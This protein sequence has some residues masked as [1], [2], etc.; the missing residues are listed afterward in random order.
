MEAGAL[1]TIIL[2][3]EQVDGL[4]RLFWE[5]ETPDECRIYRFHRQQ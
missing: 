2:I 4:W 5:W 3:V 1:S